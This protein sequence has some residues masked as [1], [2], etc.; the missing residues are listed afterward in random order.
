[1]RRSRDSLLALWASSVKLLNCV[2]LCGFAYLSS[3]LFHIFKS[4]A[5]QGSSLLFQILFVM[6]L[7][8]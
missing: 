5:L 7:Q 1:M 2:Q 3:F 6:D 8:V 4:F